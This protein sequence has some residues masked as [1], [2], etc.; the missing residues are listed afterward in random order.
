M[1]KSSYGEVLLLDN[2]V[3]VYL[4]DLLYPVNP[5]AVDKILSFLALTYSRMWIPKTV[6]KEFLFQNK[7]KKRIKRLKQILKNYPYISNCPVPISKTEIIA[8]IGSE[9][10]NNG[11]ADAILQAQKAKT[12]QH[13]FFKDITFLS[14]DKG[15]HRLAVQM[16]VN[17]LKYEDL[18][19]TLREIGVDLI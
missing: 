4:F 16:G 6:K 13:L 11:E 1:A 9:T 8:L 15:A 10:E 12:T 5:W 14:N 3:M 7:D 19:T 17:I 2:D 18:K